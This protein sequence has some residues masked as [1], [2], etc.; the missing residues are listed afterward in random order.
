[1]SVSV[2]NEG[3]EEGEREGRGRGVTSEE[4]RIETFQT[5]SSLD[6]D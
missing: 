6:R 4:S 5:T 3:R 1:M 2:S